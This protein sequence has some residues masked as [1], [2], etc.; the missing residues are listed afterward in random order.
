[1]PGKI[2][3]FIRAG[4]LGL[5]LLGSTVGIAL[6][7]GEQTYTVQ[8]TQ[9]D[10][11]HFPEVSV[12][13][14][15]TDANGDPVSL[16]P[17]TA[18]T[19]LEAG[20]PV[21]I[22]AIYQAGE[23]GPVT[24]ILAIDHS[25]SMN[26]LGKLDAAKT[27]A[28]TFVAQMRSEDAAGVIAFN[29]QVD[30][31]QPITSDK[32]AIDSAIDSIKA[33]NDTSMYDALAK[34][35][36][37]LGGVTGRRVVILLSDGLDNRSQETADS[38]LESIQGAELSIYTIGLGDPSAGTGSTSG[39]DEDAL[40]AIA[41]KSRGTYSYAPGP[42]D[43]VALY[44]QISV[45][46]QNEYQIAYTSPNALRDGFERG[47]EVRVAESSSAQANY[48]PGGVIP[49][50][51]KALSWPVFGGLL[52]GLVVL[53]A[54]PLL[55]R[56]IRSGGGPKPA[57]SKGKSRVKLTGGSAQASKPGAKSQSS[58]PRTRIRGKGG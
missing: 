24:T 46:L 32:A 9:V 2:A 8:I 15:V 17:D 31:V 3:A 6:A 35:I 28:K 57:K 49:E 40:R 33:F 53:L 58:R 30:V 26:D 42:E 19:L 18:F 39:I 21:T 50:T 45:R 14:Q 29:T 51:A 1:M 25:G 36:N 56:G 44:Q 11:S 34:S 10:T 7:Q 47:L 41:E 37:T 55:I 38:I 23:Q 54:V 13:V 22:N 20:Q 16:L 4:L 5:A 27:A 48:N 52:L 43:L 12:W